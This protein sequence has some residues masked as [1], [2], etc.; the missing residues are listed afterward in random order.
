MARTAG[1]PTPTSARRST[2]PGRAA[3][4]PC[5]TSATSAAS[6]RWPSRRTATTL[7]TPTLVKLG[8]EPLSDAFRPAAFHASLRRTTST[9]KAALLSQRH[10]A[11]VGN[12]YADEALW[13]A[14]I[15]PEARA[16]SRARSDR[17][18]AAVR[19]VLAEAITREGTTFRDYRMVNGESGRNA[20]FLDAYGQAGRPCPR[21]GRPLVKAVVAGRGTTWC[22]TCQRL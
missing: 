20:D 3:R 2:W 7:G 21:C 10:V 22:R 5:W 13:R 12:I 14:R 11:G 19:E 6:G 18:W 1:S 9:V 15:H 4:P 17:L 8:P 16:L